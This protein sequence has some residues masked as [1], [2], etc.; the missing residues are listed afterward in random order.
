MKISKERLEEIQN[1][2]IGFLTYG[3]LLENPKVSDEELYAM[4]SEILKLRNKL[5]KI[6]PFLAVHGVFGYKIEEIHDE[7]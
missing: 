1:C 6:A 5:D 2:L 4:A 3:G 7:N